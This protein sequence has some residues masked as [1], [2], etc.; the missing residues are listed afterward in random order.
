MIKVTDFGMAV[1]SDNQKKYKDENV[2]KLPLPTKW[3]LEKEIFDSHSCR[4]PLES[5][6][7]EFSEKSDVYSFGVTMWEILSLGSQPFSF[8]FELTSVSEFS[9][10][11][12]PGNKLLRGSKLET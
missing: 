10:E 2:A 1:L 9:T 12:Y 8:V 5:F 11:I 6:D 7:G 3:Y 4:T